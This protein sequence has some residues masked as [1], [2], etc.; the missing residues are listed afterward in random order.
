ML[1]VVESPLNGTVSSPKDRVV[2]K[3]SV[4]VNVL[5]VCESNALA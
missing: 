3:A 2:C 5:G 1:R 4:T